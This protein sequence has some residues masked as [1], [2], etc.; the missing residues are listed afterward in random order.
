RYESFIGKDS[1]F[2]QL[3][4][5]AVQLVL[6]N[7]PE[8]VLKYNNKGRIPA[9]I[10]EC[11]G[12]RKPVLVIGPHDGDVAAI[13][14]ETGAGQNCH[15]HETAALKLAIKEWYQQWQS[16]QLRQVESHSEIYSFNNLCKQMGELLN[17]L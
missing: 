15:Y 8:P 5:S 4:N 1:L 13:V 16:N 17:Q 7:R 10:F 2:Q 14:K 6:I 3:L 11:L 9:K 12:A